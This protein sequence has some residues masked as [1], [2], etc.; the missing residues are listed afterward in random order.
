LKDG[1]LLQFD[2]QDNAL[3]FLMAK[4][5]RREG[6]VVLIGPPDVYEAVARSFTGTKEREQ[7][8]SRVL[9]GGRSVEHEISIITACN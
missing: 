6:D 2:N 7:K 8:K 1:Q 5:N 3:S 9:F 4:E